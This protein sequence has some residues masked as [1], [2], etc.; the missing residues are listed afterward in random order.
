MRQPAHHPVTTE[1]KLAV[2]L[3]TTAFPGLSAE[4]LVRTIEPLVELG[5][6][7]IEILH[8]PA[9]AKR[10]GWLGKRL[11]EIGIKHLS[12][13][14]VAP[15]DADGTRRK[16]RS[17]A[18]DFLL[19]LEADAV[20]LG[21]RRFCGPF[22]AAFLNHSGDTNERKRCDNRR[23]AN[24]TL[25]AYQLQASGQVRAFLEYINRFEL[26][27]INTLSEMQEVLE[28]LEPTLFGGHIDS[29]HHTMGGN[30]R[31]FTDDLARFTERGFWLHRHV[32]SPDR[33]DP[34]EGALLHLIR[35]FL[36]ALQASATAEDEA[37]QNGGE[38]VLWIEAFPN[39]GVFRK[40][41]HQRAELPEVGAMMSRVVPWLRNEWREASDCR[42]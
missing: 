20:A 41:V 42:C 6:S 3:T 10:Y 17:R 8:N 40:L 12:L 33:S 15:P 13:V 18:V 27:D 2:G 21:A 9:Q 32:S 23:R 31:T 28:G 37:A 30:W 4:K 16:M 11:E 5:I 25:S 19:G 34:M 7:G 1:S 14:A 36:R 26:R 22:A 29:A 39:S 38:I 35:P 24:E